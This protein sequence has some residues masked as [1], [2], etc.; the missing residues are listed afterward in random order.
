V[1]IT[2]AIFLLSYLFLGGPAPP[3]PAGCEA[4]LEA[5]V[6]TCNQPACIAQP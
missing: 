2:D 4:Q 6:L 3:P 1:E 5:E